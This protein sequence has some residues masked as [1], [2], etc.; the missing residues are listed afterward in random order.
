MKIHRV[1]VNNIIKGCFSTPFYL[2]FLLCIII[3]FPSLKLIMC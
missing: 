3:N 1:I 2:S